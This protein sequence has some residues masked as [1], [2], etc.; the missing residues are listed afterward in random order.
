VAREG[1]KNGKGQTLPNCGEMGKNKE[2]LAILSEKKKGH[3]PARRTIKRCGT[4]HKWMVQ[5]GANNMG[6]KIVVVA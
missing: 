6:E 2:D 3:L 5:S 4:N 1:E